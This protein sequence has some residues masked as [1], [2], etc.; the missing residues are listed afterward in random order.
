MA[1]L[2]DVII[3][4]KCKHCGKETEGSALELMEAGTEGPPYCDCTDEYEFFDVINVY[5]KG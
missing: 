1:K 4:Y 3:K 5:M 2:E